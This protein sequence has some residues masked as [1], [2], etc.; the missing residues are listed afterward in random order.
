MKDKQ[1]SEERLTHFGFKQ[2]NI[3]EKT[4]RVNQLFSQVADKYDLMNDA[5][6]LGSHRLWKH[7]FTSMAAI[8][9]G[10]KVLDLAS[11]SGDIAMKLAKR[12]PH[13]QE[14]VVSD[15]N[16]EML[17]NAKKNLTNA[18]LI[19][20]I[21]Y[22]IIDAQDIDL[23][24]NHFNCITMSFGLRNVADKNKAL[25]SAYKKL[26]S[27]GQFLVL[28]F[29]HPKN[30]LVSKLYDEYSFKVIPKLGELIA[31]DKDSYQYLVESIRQHP[32]PEELRQRFADTGFVN[33][34]YYNLAMGIV[35][36]HKGV[37]P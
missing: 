9:P 34:R 25:A 4:E 18:G 27:G 8:Q 17:A 13:Y 16:Q 28:E 37:K 33:C 19:E 14:L 10:D 7:S 3:K 21:S 36:I 6:S 20:R 31:K 32:T 24:D 1:A 15:F 35:A 5:M 29:S 30:P 11:G 22:K 2:V 12:Y 23:P 26:V